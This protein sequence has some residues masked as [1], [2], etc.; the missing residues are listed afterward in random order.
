MSSAGAPLL[1]KNS[2]LNKNPRDVQFGRNLKP[3]NRN[4]V[5]QPFQ[6]SAHDVLKPTRPSSAQERGE[7]TLGA[8]TPNPEEVVYLEN[9]RLLDL[10]LQNNAF[11]DVQPLCERLLNLNSTD[12]LTP[13]KPP[14]PFRARTYAYAVYSLA[15][16]FYLRGLTNQALLIFE[17][18]DYAALISTKSSS[19]NAYYAAGRLQ[20]AQCLYDLAQSSKAQEVLLGREATINALRQSSPEVALGHSANASATSQAAQLERNFEKSQMP[21]ALRLLAFCHVKLGRFT[22]AKQLFHQALQLFPFLWSSID[23]YFSTFSRHELHAI[24]LARDTPFMQ[25]DHSTWLSTSGDPVKAASN[26]LSPQSTCSSLVQ[27]YSD[28]TKNASTM[29]NKRCG[30]TESDNIGSTTS[31]NMLRQQRVS[32]NNSKENNENCVGIEH[33]RDSL[34][35]S[36]DDIDENPGDENESIPPESPESMLSIRTHQLGILQKLYHDNCQYFFS[37]ATTYLHYRKFEYEKCIRTSYASDIQLSSLSYRLRG[38]SAYQLQ[39][40][41]QSVDIFTRFRSNFT[42]LVEST[43]YLSC[44]LWHLKRRK[45][46]ATLT[47]ELRDI[48]PHTP[49]SWISLGN[50][51]SL[52]KL[53]SRAIQAFQRAVELSIPS[54]MYPDLK[55]EQVVARWTGGSEISD[56]RILAYALCLLGHEM[57]DYSDI[58][59]ALKCYSHAIIADREFYQAYYGIGTIY[60]QKEEYATAE[61]YLQY[62]IHLHPNSAMVHVNLAQA[63][64]S[65]RKY[66]K[67]CETLRHACTLDPMNTQC[68]YYLARNLILVHDYH[69]AL[70][71]AEQVKVLAPKEPSIYELLAKIYLKVGRKVQAITCANLAV[72]YGK[73]MYD[74]KGSAASASPASQHSADDTFGGNPE[75]DMTTDGPALSSPSYPRGNFQTPSLAVNRVAMTYTDHPDSSEGTSRVLQFNS[76]GETSRTSRPES[77]TSHAS[78]YTVPAYLRDEVEHDMLQ[79]EYS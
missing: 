10:C 8:H 67:A 20:H 73:G 3:L 77:A 51:L 13:Q 72:A 12:S 63:Q 47:R 71:I 29:A 15:R 32:R 2:T 60:M 57:F 50:L 56:Q 33:Q 21:F 74:S 24:Q 52:E 16:S 34:A 14:S 70:E 43:D 28:D 27:K 45:E 30:S 17:R 9:K 53:K 54:G 41:D 37:L 42:Y 55:T 78:A 7:H 44:A 26:Q 59:G 36:P 46:L 23:G 68:K 66:G 39:R 61:R 19:E 25:Y 4:T 62:A 6:H 5:Q 79:M 69:G 22:I 64:S 35:N 48:N 1:P 38:L 65:L 11:K 18:Y 40:Y 49:Q 31:A 76:R 75:L 58:D